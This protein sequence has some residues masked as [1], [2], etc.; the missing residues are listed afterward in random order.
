MNKHMKKPDKVKESKCLTTAHQGEN[1]GEIL[2][3][4]ASA[5]RPLLRP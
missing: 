4:K 2:L 1:E 3:N 5:P